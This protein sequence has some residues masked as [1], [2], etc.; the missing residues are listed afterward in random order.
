MYCDCPKVENIKSGY[1]SGL[2][3]FLQQAQEAK[4][5]RQV[6][7]CS[8]EIA[9]SLA[10]Y[11]FPRCWFA[12]R[13]QFGWI[14]NQDTVFAVRKFQKAFATPCGIAATARPSPSV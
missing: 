1:T 10:K 4:L 11:L 6:Q 5:T 2:H 3:V 14:K 7:D 13:K 9:V 12:V 8:S